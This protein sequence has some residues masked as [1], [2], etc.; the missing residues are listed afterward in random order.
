M[1]G[2]K[3]HCCTCGVQSSKYYYDLSSY[4]NY[5]IYLLHVVAAFN[6]ITL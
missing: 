4:F 2:V 1:K 5:I 3:S 6:H